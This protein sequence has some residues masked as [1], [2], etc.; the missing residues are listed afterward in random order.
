MST[1]EGRKKVAKYKKEGYIYIG[2][3]HNDVSP[4]H[5]RYWITCC[6]DNFQGM[7]SLCTPPHKEECECGEPIV[8]NCW[9]FNEKT[10]RRRVIGSKCINKFCESRRTCADCGIEHKNR[11]NNYCN[12]CR[13][14]RCSECC[15]KIDG[16]LYTKCYSCKFG[17]R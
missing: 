9:I 6:R 15:K 7:S 13:Y 12:D 16:D 17:R 8:F 2:G 3:E 10:G 11:K 14:N 4:E 5:Y 1:V